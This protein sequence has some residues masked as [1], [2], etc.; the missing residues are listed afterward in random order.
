MSL[1]LFSPCSAALGHTV[2]ESVSSCR[3]STI[4]SSVWGRSEILTLETEMVEISTLDNEMVE[5]STL[6]NEMVEISTL[7]NEMV[8]IST[9]DTKQKWRSLRWLM[10]W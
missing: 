5:I 7:D 10:K 1:E 8:E 6:G 9:M 4:P 2:P 3:A